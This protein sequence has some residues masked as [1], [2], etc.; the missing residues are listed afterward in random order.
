MRKVALCEEG[1]DRNFPAAVDEP[2]QLVALCE[3]GVDRNF[4]NKRMIENDK[5]V[6]L[7]EEGVDRN[8]EQMIR[9]QREDRRPLRR[10]RG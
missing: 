6:A 10:G 4:D 2:K 5:M 1:V 8:H 3:E 7:C 9:F